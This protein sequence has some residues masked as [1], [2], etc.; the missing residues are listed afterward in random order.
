MK[1]QTWLALLMVSA[2]CSETEPARVTEEWQRCNAEPVLCGVDVDAG[3][4]DT[5]V[6]INNSTAADGAA[7]SARD[8]VADARA[9]ASPMCMC[10]TAKPVCLPES[11]TCVQCTASD[12]T[13]CGAATPVCD[14]AASACVECLSNTDCQDPT[15]SVCGADHT[16]KACSDHAGCG[17]LAS[18]P[19][20]E[21][22]SKTCVACT[23]DNSSA[24][25]GK[26]CDLVA[27]KRAC[28]AANPRS[29]D[30]CKPCVNDTQC[31]LGQAC[32]QMSW[33][34]D[35]NGSEETLVGW[36]C[37]WLKEGGNGAPQACNPASRPFASE[38]SLTRANDRQRATV[39]TLAAS[40]CA[41]HDAF[42]LP[43][44]RVGTG[45]SS[46]LVHDRFL[47]ATGPT[48]IEPALD[49][50][51][52]IPDNV[53]CGAGGRCVTKSASDGAYVCSVGCGN[54]N[55]DCPAGPFI[56]G[57]APPTVSNTCGI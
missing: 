57:G 11:G 12:K 42:R 24:C 33:D 44:G 25:N 27:D 9:D 16:C 10:T 5:S 29:A 52:I 32:V 40:T 45:A 36:F 53:V 30:A 50:S 31:K 15:K 14:T 4:M 22:S 8:A 20:C 49:V 17:H 48:A 38:K 1:K 55:F 6:A 46:Y 23:A 3:E 2:A 54:S 56:C 43:C 7:D 39:C 18:T 13:A 47:R 21:L 37:Q 19:A 35:G 28:G 41:A 26:V 34:T 51:T